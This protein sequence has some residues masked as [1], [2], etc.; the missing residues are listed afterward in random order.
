MT[1]SN[2]TGV[3]KGKKTQTIVLVAIVETRPDKNF[4]ILYSTV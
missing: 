2:E 1:A 4:H 3:S